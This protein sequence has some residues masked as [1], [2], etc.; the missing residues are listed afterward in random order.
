MPPRPRPKPKA[1]ASVQSPVASSSSVTVIDDDAMFIKNKAR[2]LES[3]K[4]LDEINNRNTARSGMRVN[5]D[6]EDSGS[7]HDSSPR[8]KKRKKA[9]D[10]EPTWQKSRNHARLLSIEPQSDQDSDIEILDSPTLKRKHSSL[11]RKSKGTR[12]VLTP[13]PRLN[14]SDIAAAKSIVQQALSS[15]DK[16]TAYLGDE[17]EFGEADASTDTIYQ[18]PDLQR[19]AQRYKASTKS[20]TKPVSTS[21]V[22]IADVVQAHVK[23]IPHPQKPGNRELQLQFK[24]FRNQNLGD[25]FDAI[26]EEV[27]ILESNLVVLHNQHLVFSSVTPAALKIWSKS[28]FVACEKSTYEWIKKQPGGVSAFLGGGIREPTPGLDNDSDKDDG[29]TINAE[30][31]DDAFTII[32]RSAVTKEVRLTVRPTTKCGAI[33]KAFLKKADLPEPASGG[34]PAKKR[35]GKKGAAGQNEYG[36][37]KLSIDGDRMGDDVEIGEA[38]LEDEDVVEVVGL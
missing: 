14:A 35:G 37:V 6:S 23:W 18:D 30:D 13:P 11:T 8:G 4:K 34:P 26:A 19:I 7:D 12:R 32:L 10:A 17:Y 28:D 24:I 1:A 33:V 15:P 36:N 20:P 38:D 2:T 5:S 22:D 9:K 27:S 25:M 16:E 31:A 29:P 3:W 21:N